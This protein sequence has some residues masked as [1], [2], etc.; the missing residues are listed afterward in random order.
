MERCS[1][2]IADHTQDVTDS[3]FTGFTKAV[4]EAIVYGGAIGENSATTTR[5]NEEATAKMAW[6]SASK[7]EIIPPQTPPETETTNAEKSADAQQALDAD[8]KARIIKAESD[9]LEKLA[10]KNSNITASESAQPDQPTPNNIMVDP[11]SAEPIAT[12]PSSQDGTKTQ[13][14]KPA[15]TTEDNQ[16]NANKSLEDLLFTQI[17]ILNQIKTNTGRTVAGVRTVAGNTQ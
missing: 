4:G 9:K 11:E 13:E 16:E 14:V 10:D 8:K 12:G 2:K 3:T 15:I 5:L 1:K 7:T 6:E 17:N